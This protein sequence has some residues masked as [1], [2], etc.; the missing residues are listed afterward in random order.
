MKHNLKSL[1]GVAIILAGFAIYVLM[2]SDEQ[3][4]SEDA[5]FFLPNL[6]DPSAVTGLTQININKGGESTV[7]T[8]SG[9]D[10]VVNGGFYADTEPMMRL[11]SGLRG[12]Q[13]LEA[14]TKNPENFSRLGLDVDGLRVALLANEKVIA[15]VVLGNRGAHPGTA[16]ARLA[17]EEQTWLVNGT[18]MIQGQVPDWRLKTV[19]DHGPDDLALVSIDNGSN[20]PIKI[21]RN[22][23]TSLFEVVNLTDNQQLK[24]DVH[25]SQLASGL[26][27]FTIE[28]AHPVDLTDKSERIQANYQL[29]S[30]DTIQ[31]KVYTGLS[32]SDDASEQIHWAT[33][34]MDKY[35]DWM[36]KIPSYKFDAL[37]K[38][39]AEFVEPKLGEDEIDVS[40]DEVPSSDQ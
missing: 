2:S 39:L 26:S 6:Q 7:L 30:G 34:N 11:I 36:F 1:L 17:D 5:G 29:K 40:S 37:N 9:E 21:Q 32:T 12:A 13:K 4:K 18:D 10:W 8:R 15:D 38:T 28:E 25:L 20:D 22:V 23:Q 14:K 16:F 31:V 27:R 19:V 24:A 35:R 3:N 33:I